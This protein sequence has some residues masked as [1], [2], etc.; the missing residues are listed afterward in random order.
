[1]KSAIL[2]YVQNIPSNIFMFRIVWIMFILGLIQFHI[3]SRY[4]MKLN[5]SNMSC[6]TREST[7]QPDF[8]ATW[9]LGDHPIWMMRIRVQR[10]SDIWGKKKLSANF[11]CKSFEFGIRGFQKYVE[12]KKTMVCRWDS[13]PICIASSSTVC[14]PERHMAIKD[15]ENIDDTKN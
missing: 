11:S 13:F 15:K 1:M 12:M 3:L 9:G 4:E 10:G 7:Y 5:A 14:N 2:K 8:V 6:K